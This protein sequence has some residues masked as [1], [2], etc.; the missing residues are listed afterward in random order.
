MLLV[1]LLVAAVVETGCAQVGV[2]GQALDVFEWHA[3]FQQIPDDDSLT[4]K[5]AS[6]RRRFTIQ[7]CQ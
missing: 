2:A 3:L 1:I 7:R 4:D 5:L 6:F